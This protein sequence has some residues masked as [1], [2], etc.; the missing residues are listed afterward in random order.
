M[1]QS[2]QRLYIHP[3]Q[4]EGFLVF[5]RVFQGFMNRDELFVSSLLYQ[6]HKL[7]GVKLHDD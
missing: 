3:T 4:A 2:R 1:F 6:R 5:G 7:Y